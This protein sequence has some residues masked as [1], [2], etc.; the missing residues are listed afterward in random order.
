MPDF[1][2][3]K[4][5]YFPPISIDKPM[6][7]INAVDGQNMTAVALVYKEQDAMFIA[8]APEMYKMLKD[9]ADYLE[10]AVSLGMLPPSAVQ[11]RV[12][13]LLDSINGKDKA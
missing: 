4:W 12:N 6:F 7:G 13:L 1:S 2:K 10:D 9:C 3:G 8:K 5:I 11:M